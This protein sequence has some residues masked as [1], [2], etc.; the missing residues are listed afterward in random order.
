MDNVTARKTAV[1]L[2]KTGLLEQEI[3]TQLGKSLGWVKKWLRRER[4]GET[5][6]DRKRSGRPT[7]L[8]KKVKKKIVKLLE[9]KQIGSVRKVKRKLEDMDLSLS[10]PTIA[11][12]AHEMGK[13]YKKRKKKPFLTDLQKKKRLKFA[14]VEGKKG[15]Q[16]LCKQYVFY[17]ESVFEGFT[18]SRGQ[19]V[20]ED[21]EPEP[22]PKVAHPP[23][24]MVAAAVCWWGKSSLVRIDAGVK[25]NSTV[26]INVME[27]DIIPEIRELY[28]GKRWT[29]VHDERH[30]I[31]PR[32]RKSGLV[33]KKLIF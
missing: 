9:N 20:D 32:K 18:T 3:A 19:W 27:D 29:F 1:E 21:D 24:V 2:R 16:K 13:K 14:R 30:L 22:M 10:R 8:T 25:I 33:M 31:V 4:E 6:E 23:Q 28:N 12:G 7:K 26:Y 5:L 17:D 15:P 11:K